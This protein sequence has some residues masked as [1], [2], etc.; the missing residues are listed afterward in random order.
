MM[1]VVLIFPL[2]NTGFDITKFHCILI[3]LPLP[4][5]VSSSPYSKKLV[6]KRQLWGDHSRN[7]YCCFVNF[8]SNMGWDLALWDM[9]SSFIFNSASILYLLYS[10]D[11]TELRES[12]YLSYCLFYEES[13]YC[14]NFYFAHE[15]FSFSWVQK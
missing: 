2:F 5:R 13:Y 7:F 8:N 4:L 9:L 15:G 3:L 11:S 14:W 6:C 1:S 10:I 12:V